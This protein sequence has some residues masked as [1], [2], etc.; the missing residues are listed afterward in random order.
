ME[1][2][3]NG[4]VRQGCRHFPLLP[5]KLD[6]PLIW[7]GNSTT[8]RDTISKKRFAKKHD[9]ILAYGN[10]EGTTFN[11]IRVPYTSAMSQDPNHAHKFHPDGKICLDWWPDIP[12]INPLAKERT[13]YPTQK[14]VL[15]LER[16]ISASSNRGD[17][18]FDPF[19]GCATTLVA[20]DRLN[21]E[22]SGCDLSELAI[23]LVNERI[24]NDRGLFGGAIV[25]DDPPTRTDQGEIPN[26]RTNAHRLY[27]EQEG[28]CVGCHM[29]FPFKIMEIDHILPQSR[30][31]TNASKNLQ[32]LCSHCN[33]SKGDKTMAEWT[34]AR[35]DWKYPARPP[36]P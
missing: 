35:G 16:I 10:G 8:L 29:H 1:S 22:W 13:G 30:G 34:A 14:P 27:G 3:T 19:C 32:M 28:V 2:T 15:L 6:R 17:M 5:K 11:T 24:S 7:L 4:L 23:K 12:P 18:V 20:A 36:L 25:P 9:V 31:G 21:R 33:R 26:Y